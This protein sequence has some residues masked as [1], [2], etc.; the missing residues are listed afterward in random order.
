MWWVRCACRV[1][2]VCYAAEYVW[3]G[4]V[5]EWL[6][7]AGLRPS[8][9]A[10]LRRLSPPAQTSELGVDAGAALRATRSRPLTWV[11]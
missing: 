4:L 10:R 3:L 6:R 9:P 11:R 5:E 2:N 7:S 8:E 1:V